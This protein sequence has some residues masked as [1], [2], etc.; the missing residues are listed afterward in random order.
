M[1]WLVTPVHGREALTRIIFEQRARM[2]NELWARGIETYQLVVGDDGNLDTAR[3]HGFEVL[4]RPNIL[5]FKVN[6]GFE[7]ACTT[8]GADAVAYCG[9]DDWH[10]ADYFAALPEPGRMK[11]CSL[12]AFVPPTGDRLVVIRGD[13]PYGHAP[14]IISRELLDT[15]AHRPADDTAMSAVDG[16]IVTGL[17]NGARARLEPMPV[18]ERRLALKRL[19]EFDT[20]ADRL[21][22]VD[23]KGGAEQIT[24]WERVVGTKRPRHFETRHPF[25]ELARRYPADLCERMESFYATQEAQ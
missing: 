6:E 1:L 5:G 24:P 19:Y 16:S 15:C 25:D 23:F 9:S 22:M 21:R 7:W 20:E 17:H 12:Q 14:W 13:S 8:G 4:E 3:E 10:L 11:T 18:R 2:L